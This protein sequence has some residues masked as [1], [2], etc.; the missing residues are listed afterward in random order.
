MPFSA[1]LTVFGIIF[2]QTFT[3]GWILNKILPGRAATLLMEIPPLRIP[4][5]LPVFKMAFVKTFHFM[6]EAVPVFMLASLVVFIVERMG[7]LAKLEMLASPLVHDFMGLP[8]K[9]VQVFI[10]TVIRRES[11]AAELL[12]IKSSYTN[13]QMVLNLL[14]MA[15]LLP[16]INAAIVVIKERGTATAAVM[17]S[18]VM[19]YALLLGGALHFLFLWLGI[20][21]S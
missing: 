13:V 20:T 15:F 19:L 1:T 2:A 18:S 5:P 9:S 11:G 14:I 10:K 16:C 3:A 12:H 8:E 17:L 7:G 6:K 4:K 21:F